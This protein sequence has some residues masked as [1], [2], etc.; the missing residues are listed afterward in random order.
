MITGHC[1]GDLFLYR[2]D[3][4]PTVC[5]LYGDLFVA[6]SRNLEVLCLQA[7][8]I[9]SG[10]DALGNCILAQFNGHVL[11]SIYAGG[12]ATD[13]LLAA[14]VSNCIGVADDGH[15]KLVGLGNRQDAGLIG[16]GIVF[17]LGICLQA[18]AL[19]GVGAAADFR[20]AA[21]HG[22]VCKAFVAY[23]CALCEPIAAVCQRYAVIEL[24]CRVR[25]QLDCHRGNGQAAARL[26]NECHISEVAVCT[27][28]VLCLQLIGVA[29][30]VLACGRSGA[31]GIADIAGR[32]SAARCGYDGKAGDG[33][34]LAVV[35]SGFHVALH[36]NSNF[37][38]AGLNGQHSGSCRRDNISAV[39]AGSAHSSGREVHRIVPR[40]DAGSGS[41]DFGAVPEGR[42]G[43]TD[44][45]AC[46]GFL[47]TVIIKAPGIG[48]Q[49][50]I[51]IDIED[52]LVFA[53]LD[54]DRLAALAHERIPIGNICGDR[55]GSAHSV[56]AGNSL[57]TDH[58]AAPVVNHL[59]GVSRRVVQLG[60]QNDILIHGNGLSR[61][62]PLVTQLPALENLSLRD[63]CRRRGFYRG[64]AAF[65]VKG[66][67]RVALVPDL[68]GH[69]AGVLRVLI[70]GINDHI[71]GDFGIGVKGRSAA[72]GYH[73]P[74]V[75]A[76][77]LE[78]RVLRDSRT[79][80]DGNHRAAR[81]LYVDRHR[82][83]DGRK[84]GVEGDVLR[85]HGLAVKD[86]GLTLA[87]FIIVPAQEFHAVRFGV[88]AVGYTVQR[89]LVFLGNGVLFN[90][91][92]DE[93]DFVVVAGVIE[94]CVVVR[95]PQS[96]TDTGFEGK[97]GYWILI[98]GSH[99]II[100]SGR[101][102]LVIEFVL[103]SINS[104]CTG[105]SRK[106]FDIIIRRFAAI[107][108]LGAKEFS[109]SK[110]HCINIDLGRTAAR[111]CSPCGAT[112]H[113]W[114]LVR[115]IRFI[116]GRDTA[117]RVFTALYYIAASKEAV[118][119]LLTPK[120]H[121]IHIALI[122]DIDN[123]ASVAA[124]G[125]LLNGLRREA[126]HLLR[127]GIGALS[128]STFQ[129]LGLVERIVVIVGV[130]L[131]VDHQILCV[132]S[133]LPQRRYGSR[134][135]Y[136]IHLAAIHAPALEYKARLGGHVGAQVQRAAHLEYGVNVIAAVG[137]KGDPIA[138]G[139]TGVKLLDAVIERQAVNRFAAQRQTP[140]QNAL[141]F[142][143]A[144]LHDSGG[145]AHVTAVH[146]G[147]FRAGHSVDH[148]ISGHI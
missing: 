77:S 2:R 126:I 132:F 31:A 144:A 94:F 18:M 1:N 120:A 113:S 107:P 89:L 117:I 128:G 103:L 17:D 36:H 69:R 71:P 131:P 87:V 65:F 100:R 124:D 134:A 95:V 147:P 81:S 110:R 44:H 63:V 119:P 9:D 109:A 114:P 118:F 41:A 8:V 5:V 55:H 86:I 138:F 91:S 82:M 129:G 141:C 53:A 57:P 104:C 7:H 21:F 23:E 142:V 6:G 78:L 56:L 84:A 99:P 27:A 50:H 43:F 90:A 61:V 88:R 54:I 45:K 19:N 46:H 4:Q 76:Q 125:L 24:A 13:R 49:G 116:L 136:A 121:S 11:S 111:S 148:G 75:L 98:F 96:G 22:N 139:D 26:H 130:L 70:V 79:I 30:R 51:L 140:A 92:V 35:G 29:A 62:Q 123:G 20:L 10:V 145:I 33:V 127:S 64:D 97:A 48:S 52:D 146:G 16:D 47:R 102:I 73:I 135:G 122:P 72:G 83:G 40:F 25:S 85:G 38:R 12:I 106:N 59:N 115:N 32:Q 143:Q 112:V 28:E 39:V 68:V 15:N 34:V 14:I 66:G 93:K 105:L 58:S 60:F 101:H 37:C 108:S 42:L 80:G 74:A 3:L 133:G 137:I 67:I